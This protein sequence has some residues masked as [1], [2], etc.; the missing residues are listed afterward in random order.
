MVTVNG[1]ATSYVRHFYGVPIWSRGF[2]LG[3]YLLTLESVSIQGR[4]KRERGLRLGTR[5]DTRGRAAR[6]RLRKKRDDASGM[7]AR[8]LDRICLLGEREDVEQ[9]FSR[10]RAQRR[11][12]LRGVATEGD[13]CETNRR[14]FEN[15]FFASSRHHCGRQGDATLNY[16]R[17]S[18]LPHGAG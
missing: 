9:E 3:G 12:E 5:A 6:V 7:G 13:V 8:L 18:T 17:R 11:E 16:A 15:Y 2:V 10:T 4:R 1:A 14:A